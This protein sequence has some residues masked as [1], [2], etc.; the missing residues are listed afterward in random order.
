VG[1]IT[2]LNYNF[3]VYLFSTRLLTYFKNKFLFQVQYSN[4]DLKRAYVACIVYTC[5][6]NLQIWKW[7]KIKPVVSS[8]ANH[9]LACKTL[10]KVWNLVLIVKC[11]FPKKKNPHCLVLGSPS[12]TSQPSIF[13]AH[14]ILQH[15]AYEVF[16]TDRRV[17][18][19]FIHQSEG[20]VVTL[21]ALNDRLCLVT[22][23]LSWVIT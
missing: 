8:L 13:H 21:D 18:W 5:V 17:T 19:L 1:K 9:C 6:F 16:F 22:D 20:Y 14:I 3:R 12:I 4:S 15:V 2:C 7:S 10:R 23:N 11:I